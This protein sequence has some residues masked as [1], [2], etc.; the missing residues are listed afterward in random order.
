M[1][2]SASRADTPTAESGRR[3]LPLAGPVRQASMVRG[4]GSGRTG[5]VRQCGRQVGCRSRGLRAG[6]RIAQPHAARLDYVLDQGGEVAAVLD[7]GPGQFPPQWSL[8]TI[9]RSRQISGSARGRGQGGAQC[10]WVRPRRRPADPG[11][12]RGGWVARQWRAGE[13]EQNKNM[14]GGAVSR[15]ISLFH[16]SGRSVSGSIPNVVTNMAGRSTG[17]PRQ[18]WSTN[19]SSSPDTITSAAAARASSR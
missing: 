3:D 2:N 9:P 1:V 8:A 11:G 4:T 6:G 12:G 18:G 10:G 19:R 17:M 15:Y 16:H 13:H 7:D 14:S 5:A